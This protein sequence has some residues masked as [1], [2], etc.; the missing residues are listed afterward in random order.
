MC[1]L[2]TISAILIFLL[3]FGFRIANTK[4]V[5][6]DVNV[7]EHLLKIL[8][9]A[10]LPLDEKSSPMI[11]TKSQENEIDDRRSTDGEFF[12]HK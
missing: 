1:F 10:E 5:H 2:T 12:V 3:I 7:N 11:Q 8:R 6:D 4:N 9:D